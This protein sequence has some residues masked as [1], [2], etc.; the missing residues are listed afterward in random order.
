MMWKVYKH[1]PGQRCRVCTEPTSHWVDMRPEDTDTTGCYQLP[2][3][4]GWVRA[5]PLSSGEIAL[6]LLMADS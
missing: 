1:S 3:G 4:H 2:C 6:A 5:L